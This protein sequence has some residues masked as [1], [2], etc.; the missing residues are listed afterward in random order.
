[1]TKK[2]R[3]VRTF[4]SGQPVTESPL[5]SKRIVHNQQ[6]ALKPYSTMKQNKKSVKSRKRLQKNFSAAPKPEPSHCSPCKTASP[7]PGQLHCCISD[8]DDMSS[9][10]EIDDDDKCCVSNLFTPSF[11]LIFTK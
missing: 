2:R 8:S 7:K 4:I 5:Q 11:S 3:C 1:V 6:K 9:Q 10:D